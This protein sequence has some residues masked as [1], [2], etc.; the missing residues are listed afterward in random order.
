MNYKNIHNTLLEISNERIKQAGIPNPLLL[1]GAAAAL[2][3]LG[4]Y[5]LGK[6]TERRQSLRNRNLAFGAGLA[7]GTL[8]PDVVRRGA[9][10][11]QNLGRAL[12]PARP[13]PEYGPPPGYA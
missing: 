10:L 4:A 2:T 6:A 13:S 1:G 11:L 8:A 5:Q 3:G 9:G 7:A 12:A